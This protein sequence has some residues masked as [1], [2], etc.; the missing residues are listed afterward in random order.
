[1]RW[2]LRALLLAAVILTVF[3]LLPRRLGEPIPGPEVRAVAAIR[4]IHTAETQYYSQFNRY[5]TSLAELGPPASGLAHASAADLIG[6]DLASGVK[7]GYVFTVTAN[8]GG[9]IIQAMPQVFHTG[10]RTFYS[11]RTMVVHEHY[12]PE[13][14]TPQD[15][16]SK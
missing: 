2:A 14:A 10:G 1:V 3:A 9:Y 12:G 4:T 6:N 13:P 15:P 5:A 8:R 11:D 16:E 7:Q